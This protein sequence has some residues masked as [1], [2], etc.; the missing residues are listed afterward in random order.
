VTLARRRRRSAVLLAVA[1]AVAV[2]GTAAGL[3]GVRR[4]EAGRKLAL[5]LPGNVRS[6]VYSPRGDFLVA[7]T[8]Q[9]SASIWADPEGTLLG[10][11]TLAPPGRSVEALEVSSS[12]ELLAVA[13]EDGTVHLW[14]IPERRRLRE[15]S[16]RLDSAPTALAF[17]FSERHLAAVTTLGTVACWSLEEEHDRW[18]HAIWAPCTGTAIG[19]TSES[20]LRVAR[21]DAIDELSLATR[22]F[23][24]RAS[25]PGFSLEDGE[26][27]LSADG[28]LWARFATFEDRGPEH[29][30]LHRIT[31]GKIAETIDT[32][33]R[34]PVV[35][36]PDGE[37]AF[38]RANPVV[39]HSVA[40]G[41]VVSVIELPAKKLPV[42]PRSSVFWA[43]P[44][45][46]P[47]AV[48]SGR[49]RVAVAVDATVH[50][51]SFRR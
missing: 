10:E 50:V 17:T 47:V 2:L 51:V 37:L 18:S 14:S 22:D 3:W 48:S 7:S 41:R 13:L 9:G 40:T 27:A 1:G 26:N 29:V 36:S 46:G 4:V 8:R 39:V 11:L 32:D 30:R 16:P 15:L 6:L 49:D 43:P 38:E 12:G 45:H 19:F 44:S 20:T 25:T 35:F 42:F 21:F 24:W 33:W 5:E 28:S 34:A 31:A 23:V